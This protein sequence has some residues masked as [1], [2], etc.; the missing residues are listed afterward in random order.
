MGIRQ[1]QREQR[2]W[3]ILRYALDL[4]VRQGYQETTISQIAEAAS[5]STGLMFHYF[6]SKEDLYLALVSIGV[7]G[8]NAPKELTADEPLA[9]FRSLLTGL[10]SFTE[11]EP[12][13]PQLFIL[14]A[15]AQRE[16]APP[17]VR[18]RALSVDQ[19]AYSARII[20]HGQEMGIM[21]QADPNA[22]SRTFWAAVQGA[23]EQWASHPEMDAPDPEWL[24]GIL[25]DR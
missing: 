25:I 3:Q 11:N 12:W 20:Q 15:R 22:L 23:M 7:E 9:Y 16:G 24:L 14:M 21:R 13:V 18:E 4:F 6:P 2:R 10:F 5:M 17:A 8:A 19:I 1:E